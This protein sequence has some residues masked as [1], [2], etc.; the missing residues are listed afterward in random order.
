MAKKRKSNDSKHY[1]KIY[2]SHYGPIGR[3]ED[4]RSL[5][6]HHIDGDH[7]N[8]D[9]SNLKLV[10]IQEHYDIH[11]SQGDWAACLIMGERMKLTFDEMSKL[12]SKVQNER[13]RL[14]I[15]SFSGDNHPM[16]VASKDGTHHFSAVGFATE[17]NNK[18]VQ[19]GKHNWQKQ[20]DGSSFSKSLVEDGKHH[21]VTDNPAKK[22]LSDGRHAS[23]IRMCCVGCHK[24]MPKNQSTLHFKKCSKNF[25]T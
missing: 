5:E 16:K 23:Q 2:E 3:D 20:S 18:L 4:G 15:H 13:L 19:E 6:I 1:R 11:Y 24:E 14:G 22:L 9:I 8:N 10:T 7:D 21:F 17:R 25:V 12:S